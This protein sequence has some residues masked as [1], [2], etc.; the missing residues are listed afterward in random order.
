MKRAEFKVVAGEE[1]TKSVKPR[2]LSFKE[3]HELEDME[4]QIHAVEAEVV[5][6]ENLFADAEFFRKHAAQVNQLT[7]ELDAA[8][9]KVAQLYARWEE[10]EAIRL[11]PQK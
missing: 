6:I 10:L 8:K 11:A 9:R 2:K 1:K 4:A 5:R 3:Q 7:E